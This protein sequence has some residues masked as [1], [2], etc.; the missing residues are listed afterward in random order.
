LDRIRLKGYLDCIDKDS[1]QLS[2]LCFPN[3]RDE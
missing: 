1:V 3:G 2:D